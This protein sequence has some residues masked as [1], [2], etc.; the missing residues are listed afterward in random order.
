MTRSHIYGDPSAIRSSA[1]RLR[2][3]A[4]EI[5]DR[6]NRLE[7]ASA[8]AEM[9]GPYAERLRLNVLQARVDALRLAVEVGEEALSL[10]RRAARVEEQ[11][12]SSEWLGL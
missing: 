9:T 12:A 5:A 4:A 11:I 6:A 3:L 8:A 7:S 10:Q 1:S 2:Q